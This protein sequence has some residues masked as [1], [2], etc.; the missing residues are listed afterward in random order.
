MRRILWKCAIALGYL[1]ASCG[2]AQDNTGSDPEISPLVMSSTLS[3]QKVMAIAEDSLGQVWLGTFRGLNR[4]NAHGFHQYFCTDDSLDLPDNQIN[5]LFNDSKN[6]FWIGTIH[7][8]ALLNDRDKFDHIEINQ[9]ND[10]GY[11]F[12]ENSSGDI[13]LNLHSSLAK[14]NESNRMFEV[15]I[16]DL[17]QSYAM[18]TNAFTDCND[19]LWVANSLYLRRYDK[20]SYALLDSIPLHDYVVC[21]YFDRDTRT[22]WMGGYKNLRK[23]DIT[24][25]TFSATPS[26]V[27]SHPLYNIAQV[28]NIYPYAR[29]CLLINTFEHGMFIYDS[30]ADRVISQNDS[31]FP[32][33]PPNFRITQ[34]FKDSWGNL[35]FGSFDQGY[36]VCNSSSQRF[37]AVNKLNDEFHGKSVLSVDCDSNGNLWIVTIMDGV[38]HYNFARSTATKIDIGKIHQLDNM[39]FNNIT[40][41]FVD[42]DDHI[43]LASLRA[44]TVIQATYDT[45]SDRFSVLKTYNIIA[46]HCISQDS[47]G[48]IYIGMG[49]PKIAILKP[50]ASTFTEVA[51]NTTGHGFV[52]AILPMPDRSILAGSLMSPIVQYDPYTAQYATTN[53]DNDE[54]NSCLSRGAYI[55]TELYRDSFGEVWIGTIGNGV[56]RYT[57]STGKVMRIPGAPCTDICSFQEDRQGHIWIST[58]YGLGRI[59]RTSLQFINYYANDGIGGNQFYDRASCILPDGRLVFGG[60]HGITIFDPRDVSVSEPMAPVFQDL[61]IHNRI[62]S[63]AE[64]PEVIR[65]SLAKCPDVNLD[66]TQNGFS[67]SFAVLDNSGEGKARYQYLLDG[68]DPQWVDA[69]NINEAYYGNLDPGCYTFRVRC[70]GYDGKPIDSSEISLNINVKPAPW[71]STWAIIA[72]IIVGIL[73]ILEVMRHRKHF[74]QEKEKLRQATLEKEQ[75]KRVNKM[76]MSFFANV[77]HEFRTPLTMIAAPITQLQND[78][79][80]QP[81][82]KQLLGIVQHSVDRMLRLVNQLLDFNKLENDTLKLQVAETDL[83]GTLK[84]LTELFKINAAAKNI[85]L[86]VKGLED[87]MI[88]P[89][90]IDKVDKIVNNLLSNAIKF[91]P[92]NG[93]ITLSL[94]VANDQILI[95]VADSGPGIPADQV[96]KIFERYYQIKNQNSGAYNWGT[97]IGLY[98]ARALAH[99]HHGSLNVANRAVGGAIFTLC[100]PASDI[101]TPDEHSA[102]ASNIFI[103]ETDGI[104]Q[105]TKG[106]TGTVHDM[107]VLIAD[108]D[109][110]VVRYLQFLLSTR[111]NIIT[112][113]NA[114]DA[115]K[116]AEEAHPDLIISDVVMPDID[117]YE[118]TRKLKE[119]LQ[120]CHIP[121]ILVT[122][123]STVENQVEGLNSGADAY[124]TKPFNPNYVIALVQSQ[125]ANREKIRKLLTK[126]TEINETQDAHT[127]DLSPLDRTFMNELYALMENELS[128]MKLD[129]NRITELMHISRTKL[130]YKVKGLTGTNPGAFFKTYKLNRAAQLLKEGKHTISEI[131]DMTGFST[132]SHFSSSFKKQFGVSPSEYVQPS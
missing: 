13:F 118:L 29:N 28:T 125:L 120:L 73:I 87:P 115:F 9:Q 105:E 92:S 37:N 55:P 2:N 111:Y 38:Y 75:E 61:K 98:Y 108:D 112:C 64:H 123:K 99:L 78:S 113:F 122:A 107:T 66:H 40:S 42:A 63:P 1:A 58:Q 49:I 95:S 89:V 27:T 59:D 69:S 51:A 80:L 96:D 97:G 19:D 43:W 3:N 26:G 23:F 57:P 130:Y 70:V 24:S 5:C 6:R 74:Y 31:D 14:Y 22:L 128:N 110:D 44:N 131:A 91:T 84:Q 68:H 103:K 86:S 39:Q 18:H 46:P 48:T 21:S 4:Y 117:G 71:F 88:V 17:Y 50:G 67:I 77:S 106:E 47:E 124:V 119:D 8:V 82:H 79:G 25:R 62:I 126:S 7:G 54:W 32:F 16:P 85:T 104:I 102:K 12:F 109:P 30:T 20:T 45:G 36:A 93:T 127:S 132:L 52:S 114:E 34:I 65:C 94:D 83:S 116:K 76:N 101:Y 100:I 56:L 129:I 11:Q 121:I 72:Y 60:T 15:V 81:Q 33:S 41:A 53:I 35:W 10:C 90:D